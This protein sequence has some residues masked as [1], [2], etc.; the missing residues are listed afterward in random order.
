[1][2]WPSALNWLDREDGI[3]IFG[4]DYRA[5]TEVSSGTAPPSPHASRWYIWDLDNDEMI[6]MF[7]APWFDDSAGYPVAKTV[8]SAVPNQFLANQAMVMRPSGAVHKEGQLLITDMDLN[9]VQKLVWSETAVRQDRYVPYH[10]RLEQNYPNP[11]NPETRIRFYLPEA[12]YVE[13]SIYMLSGKKVRSLQRGYLAAG[14]HSVLVNAA[15][16]PSGTYLYTL[17]NN[18][19]SVSRK[20]L[21]L[22]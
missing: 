20:M 1:V 21:L 13:L 9:C 5:L 4:N 22:K 6:A 2:A 17:H 3:I 10:L 7:G 14:Q 11:F 16:F 19:F 8:S 15:D 18:T 12:G